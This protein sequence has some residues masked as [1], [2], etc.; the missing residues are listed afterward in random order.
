MN[1]ITLS[2]LRDRAGAA[3]TGIDC[4]LQICAHTHTYTHTHTPHTPHTLT[5]THHTHHTHTPHTHTYTHTHTNLDV[6]IAVVSIAGVLELALPRVM[7]DVIEGAVFDTHL[8]VG[9]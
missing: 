2:P 3:N 6:E 7:V 4:A 1:D 9:R 5:H 8:P